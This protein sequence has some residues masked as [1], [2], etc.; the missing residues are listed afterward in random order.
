MLMWYIIFLETAVCRTITD[1]IWYQLWI[2]VG[3]SAIY[4]LA[5]VWDER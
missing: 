1:N 5:K 2:M 4:T 3:L